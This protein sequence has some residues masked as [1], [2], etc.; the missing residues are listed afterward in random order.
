MGSEA[1]ELPASDQSIRGE[2]SRTRVG[3]SRLRRA[4]NS[5]FGRCHGTKTVSLI[6]RIHRRIRSINESLKA[7]LAEAPAFFLRLERNLHGRPTSIGR[8]RKSKPGGSAL[9]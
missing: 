8:V 4:R 1:G 3:N 7:A 9:D 5:S 2:R 6:I